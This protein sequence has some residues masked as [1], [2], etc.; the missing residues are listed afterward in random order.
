MEQLVRPPETDIPTASLR[1]LTRH[2]HAESLLIERLHYEI[3]GTDWSPRQKQ[4]CDEALEI[5]Q[6]CHAGMMRDD[7][8]YLT[9]VLR[10]A[11][12]IVSPRHFNYRHDPG[13]LIVA[14]LHDTVEDNTA[15]IIGESTLDKTDMSGANLS[16]QRDQRH[17]ALQMITEQFNEGVANDVAAVSN[18][19]YDKTDTSVEHRQTLYRAKVISVLERNGRAGLVKVSDF[20]DNCLGIEYNPSWQKR[21]KLARKYQP[22]LPAMRKYIV[23]S[24]LNE[25]TKQDLL[26]E[27]FYAHE[28]CTVVIDSGGIEHT[29]GRTVLPSLVSISARN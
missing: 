22:L 11:I 26:E 16:N 17:R 3:E 6:N 27:L 14:L 13:A 29:L 28:L 2:E 15:A 20:I 5:A 7:K 12:R 19:I 24:T 1:E 21:F 9:H 8:S 25:P 18:D 4:L 10:V 23:E